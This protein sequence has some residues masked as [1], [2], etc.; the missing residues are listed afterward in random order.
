M[1]RDREAKQVKTSREMDE[2][3]KRLLRRKWDAEKADKSGKTDEE[4]KLLLKPE[5]LADEVRNWQ[6]NYATNRV[7]KY[8]PSNRTELE[9]ATVLFLFFFSSAGRYPGQS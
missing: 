7:Q 4:H 1:Q 6:Q 3:R 2:E 9:R 8:V 5:R